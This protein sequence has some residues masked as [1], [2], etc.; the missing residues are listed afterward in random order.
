MSCIVNI[1]QGCDFTLQNLPYG[2][3][4]TK[5]ND[6]HRIG[7]AIGDYVLDLSAIKHLFDGPLMKAHQVRKLLNGYL[8]HGNRLKCEKF[9]IHN[10]ILFLSRNSTKIH[11]FNEKSEFNN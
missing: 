9:F 2:I 10:E 5:G 6:R 1:P 8:L 3:F 4:S 7:V 11:L